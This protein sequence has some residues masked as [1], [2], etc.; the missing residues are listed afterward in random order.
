MPMLSEIG[1][2]GENPPLRDIAQYRRLL[3]YRNRPGIYVGP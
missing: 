1:R 3:R 2:K